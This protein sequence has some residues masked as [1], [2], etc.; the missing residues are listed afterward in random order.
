LLSVAIIG[1]SLPAVRFRYVRAV[2]RDRERLQ[3]LAIG[4]V[5]AGD[6]ALVS[7]VLHLLV[8]WPAAIAAVAAGVTVVIPLSLMAGGV[9]RLG[10]YGGR[11]LVHVLWVA[12]FSLVVGAVYVVIVLG[13]GKAP[14]D[15]SDR[16]ILALSTLAAAIVTVCYLPL[17]R[18]LSGVGRGEFVAVMGP[19]CGESTLLTAFAGLDRPDEGTIEAGAGRA[20]RMRAERVDERACGLP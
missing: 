10:P 9:A 8:G 13:L 18:G 3:W 17:L 11:L 6:A 1:S 7:L 15:A 12:G 5:T 16:E 4:A 2:A 14:S 19:D 20:V